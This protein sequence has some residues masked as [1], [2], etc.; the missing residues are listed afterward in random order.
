MHRPLAA[1][2]LALLTAC[3]S[4]PAAQQEGR[5][6]RSVAGE[7]LSGRFAAGEQDV[8]R[9]AAAY[10]AAAREVDD[11]VI[12]GRA[13]EFALAAGEV[14]KAASYAERLLAAGA[15][16]EASAPTSRVAAFQADDLPRLTLAV[17]A[18][19]AR[20]WDEALE[21]LGGGYGSSL[22]QSLAFMLEGWTLYAR[23]GVEAG[24]AHLASPPQGAFAGFVPLH[25][26]LMY[27]LAGRTEEA[28]GA[29][30][31]AV[32][33]PASQEAAIAF[34]LMQEREGRDADAA[35][36]YRRMVEN[37][38]LT[39][40]VGRMGLV[41]LGEPLAGESEAFAKLARKAPKR[42]V[43]NARAGAALVLSDFA[44]AA[45]DQASQERRAAARAGFGDIELALNGPLGFA[46]L[47]T[48]LD[49]DQDAAQYLVGAISA[50]YGQPA[51]TQGALAKVRPSSP[52]Y[53]FAARD[54]AA[55]LLTLDQPQAAARL[56]EDYLSQDPLSPDVASQLSGI[57]AEAERWD[58]ALASATRAIEA[59][60]ALAAAGEAEASELW[61]YHFAR[62]ATAI[63]ADRWEAGEAD[64]RRSLELS[65][66][67]P[68]VL[69]Y[70]GYSYVERGERLDEAFGMIEQA[71]RLDPTSGAITDSLGWAHYQRGEYEEAVRYL[72]DAVRLEP[73]DDVITD[74]L[75][76]A[77]WQTGR[78]AEA[79]YEWRRVLEIDDL[80]PEL[81]VRVEAKLGGEPP[82]PGALS[83]A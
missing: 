82:L 45:F 14:E 17:V 35:D 67:E 27:D 58:D 54:R 63:E 33:T 6:G 13:F 70:L 61:F 39:R 24:T 19:E 73:G 59:A 64:M 56:L 41:R 78:E 74:H 83:D 48:H 32:Q 38:G 81:R 11:P 77:Y 3:A 15:A 79:R 62:G 25:A 29:Y 44:R 68:A 46:R 42:L 47:A 18:M 66:E 60:E 5:A 43:R 10:E 1:A 8:A 26:A 34:A 50:T 7:Y 22:G 40:R 2:T 9:A 69:N 16:P 36:L 12:A 4:A 76:D 71:L 72:E 37:G 49:E 55:A 53:G 57:Y 20:D 21:R 80:D 51:T 30:A 28:R 52:Y 23:D 65:P 31:T 75:G